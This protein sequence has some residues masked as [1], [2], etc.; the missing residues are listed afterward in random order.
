MK[1]SA[2][3]VNVRTIRN[4]NANE[5]LQL[6]HGYKVSYKTGYTVKA[7]RE[8]PCFYSAE[9]VMERAR[10]YGESNCKARI[11]EVKK[12]SAGYYSFELCWHYSQKKDAEIFIGKDTDMYHMIKVGS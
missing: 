8:V 3:K 10:A 6:K 7:M 5:T 1:Y 4:M 2:H 9:E 11:I 12:D